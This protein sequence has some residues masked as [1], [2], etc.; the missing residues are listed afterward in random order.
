MSIL[1]QMM[2][3]LPG[4][5]PLPEPMLTYCQRGNVGMNFSGFG[6]KMSRLLFKKMHLKMSSGKCSFCLG[7]NVNR[8]FHG[9]VDTV[10]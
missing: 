9:K 8:S 7:Y 10:M 3:C 4:A 1:L 5:K 2:A 6:M